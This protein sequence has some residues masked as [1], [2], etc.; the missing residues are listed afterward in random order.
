MKKIR[1]IICMAVILIMMPS[2]SEKTAENEKLSVTASFYAMYDFANLIGGDKAEVYN[3]TEGGGEPHDFEPSAADIVRIE[4]SDI[5]IYSSEDME[6]WSEKVISS[7]KS[8]V[9]IVKAAG[10]IEE[11]TDPH[12]WLDPNNACIQ[13]ENICNAFCSADRGNEEYYRANLNECKKKLAELDKKYKESIPENK[14]IVVSHEAYGY[15]CSAYNMEQIALNGMSDEAEASPSRIAEV[16]EFVK[17]NGIK[18]IYAENMGSDKIM[19][20][21]AEGSGAQVLVLSPFEGETDGRNYFEVMY[22]NLAAL[23][24]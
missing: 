24:K 20:T 14:K 3:L 19:Q 8:D 17:D 1:Y 6:S 22:D 5:F 16:I 11:N 13:M 18:Y 21:V 7:V 2:C 9:L 4:N 12:V 23:I 10:G 15:L